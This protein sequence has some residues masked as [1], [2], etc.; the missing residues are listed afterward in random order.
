M[1]ILFVG[2]GAGGGGTESHFVALASA[3]AEAQHEVAA[4]VRPGDFIYRALAG[5]GAV[6]LYDGCFDRSND[7][8][9]AA[10][11]WRAARHFRPDWIVGSYKREYLSVGFVARA[12]RARVALF[13]HI[14]NM[15]PSS[16]RLLPR[17]ADRFIVP[18]IFL[19]DELVRR[20]TPPDRIQVLPNPVDLRR[21]APEPWLRSRIRRELDLSDDDVLVGFV[22][23]LDAAKGVHPY[24]EAL[25]QAMSRSGRL[26]ALWVG[27]GEAAAPLLERLWRSPNRQRHIHTGWVPDV[28]PF[29]AA[30]DVLALPSVGPETFGRVSIEAQACGVPVLASRNGGI[31][32]TLEDGGSGLLL[33]P[34]DVPAWS[35]ALARICDDDAGRR[36]M[37][38]A[39]RQLVSERF[40][41]KRVARD[42]ER[43]LTQQD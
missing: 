15:G 35:D 33:P 39:G 5:A 18:S 24:A 40:C 43:I 17:L 36:R 27:D 16:A 8:A 25:E 31:P 37:G 13:K 29:Y 6:R 34:A 1:R 38:D 42:F 7:P 11:V 41:H 12:Q 26:R 21:Y 14:V 3:M 9:G 19:R 20:G 23:R 32:E 2:T 10:S 30:L 28:R 22:G 4:V